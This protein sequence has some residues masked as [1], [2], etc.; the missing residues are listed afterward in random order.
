MKLPRHESGSPLFILGSGRCGSTFW[1][2]LLCRA[3]GIWIW[4]EHG[5]FL[6]PLLRSRERLARV[7]HLLANGRCDDLIAADGRLVETD[8]GRLAWLS[9]ISLDDYDDLL[10]GFIDASMRQGLPPGRRRWGFKEIRY[11]GPRNDTPR[12]LLE[13]FPGGRVIHTLRHPRRVIASLVRSWHRGL[14]E[15]APS[16][17]ASLLAAYDVHASR[18]R[19]STD[20]LLDLADEVPEQVVTV[21]L[22]NVPAGRR[23]I[24]TLLG[25]TLPD[26]EAV[27]NAAPDHD[28]DL[29]VLLDEAWQRW[30]QP[31]LATTRRAGYD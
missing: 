13:L 2:T 17:T 9:G 1:Q 10:R 15:A 7:G 20:Y 8:G 25:T 19:D 12:I 26:D 22:E 29:Q 23:A 28:A 5:G 4:G 31:L 16:D 3:P 30:E 21:R 24:E 27:V 6:T 14:A 11:G 18:W